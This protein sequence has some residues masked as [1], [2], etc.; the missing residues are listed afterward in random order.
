MLT[1]SVPPA[2]GGL[3]LFPM[4]RPVFAILPSSLGVSPIAR[5]LPSSTAYRVRASLLSATLSAIR[6]Q[7]TGRPLLR[8]ASN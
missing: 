7:A 1:L 2:D 6:A 3:V 8:C 5:R 4:H